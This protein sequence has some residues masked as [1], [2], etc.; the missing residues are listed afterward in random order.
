LIPSSGANVKTYRSSRE[1]L[2][3]V[4]CVLAT[5]RSAFH[6]SPLE[7]TI[8][9]LSRGRHY[10]WIGIYLT[11]GN[12]GQQLLGGG[13]DPHPGLMARPETRSKVLISMKLAGREF[14]VLDVESDQENAFGVEDRVLLENAANL[15]AR[16]LAGPGRFIVRK[17]RSQAALE[18][19]SAAAKST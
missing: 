15:V 13:G 9:L 6:H 7:D 19:S 14:G 2:S 3:Q 16:F 4:A 10:T 17:A 12:Q 5:K 18:S 1:L 11:L 8:G